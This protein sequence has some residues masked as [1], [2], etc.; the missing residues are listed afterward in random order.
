MARNKT[1]EFLVVKNSLPR[2]P[3]GKVA[4]RELRAELEAELTRG[5]ALDPEEES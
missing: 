5:G 3:S 1:P 2:T 4:G